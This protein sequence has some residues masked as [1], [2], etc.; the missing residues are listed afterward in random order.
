MCFYHFIIRCLTHAVLAWAASFTIV[1]G[2]AVPSAQLARAQ[3]GLGLSAAGLCQEPWCFVNTWVCCSQICWMVSAPLKSKW[4]QSPGSNPAETK[5]NKCLWSL[6]RVLSQKLVIGSFCMGC[7]I[8]AGV[9]RNYRL[10]ILFVIWFRWCICMETAMTS[11][12]NL[13]KPYA[14]TQLEMSPYH[15]NLNTL[16]SIKSQLI[17]H[18]CHSE[19]WVEASVVVASRAVEGGKP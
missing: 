14:F 13:K 16:F 2:R 1:L 4:K 17:K 10:L 9:P 8:T 19:L 12:Y 7:R 18:E 15:Q 6:G 11:F 5:G 3:P